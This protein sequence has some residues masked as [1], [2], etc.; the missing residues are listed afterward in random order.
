MQ[1]IAWAAA[2]A[3]GGTSCRVQPRSWEVSLQ[4]CQCQNAASARERSQPGSRTGAKYI[5]ALG[6]NERFNEPTSEGC[7]DFSSRAPLRLCCGPFKGLFPPLFPPPSTILR[8]GRG[9][10]ERVTRGRGR[11]RAGGGAGRGGARGII[12]GCGRRRRG[13]QDGAVCS[14]GA[15]LRR[16]VHHQ[17]A[18]PKGAG[19]RPARP[20]AGWGVRGG[21]VLPSVSGLTPASP[22]CVLQG[23]IEYLVKWKGWAI[24]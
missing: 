5:D 10:G 13:A 18:H 2:A 16:R 3:G 15:R 9:G 21:E 7:A 20:G 12:M 19:G 11:A 17:A 6:V 14:G 22:P 8:K 23:R 24:K 4:R 1:A